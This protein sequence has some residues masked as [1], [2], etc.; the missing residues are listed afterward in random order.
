M[1]NKIQCKYS[2]FILGP[3][4]AFAPG[5]IGEYETVDNVRC[6][7]FLHTVWNNEDGRFNEELDDICQA[8]YGCS[9]SFIR[10]I[11]FSRLG[12]VSDF[13]HLVKLEKT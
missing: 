5:I 12:K 2:D 11:W 13:W 10:S 8:Y 6:R 3:Q 1:M 9:F 7:S 4:N